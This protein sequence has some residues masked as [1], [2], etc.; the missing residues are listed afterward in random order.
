[1]AYD[2]K[3]L[4]EANLTCAALP[5]IVPELL[6]A[7]NVKVATTKGKIVAL[8]SHLSSPGPAEH[9]E[10]NLGLVG[11]LDHQVAAADMHGR[12]ISAHVCRYGCL[13]TSAKQGLDQLSVL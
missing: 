1:M 3:L 7:C 11:G 5:A 12:G 9:P 10:H 2:T 13:P 8:R 6:I 4:F